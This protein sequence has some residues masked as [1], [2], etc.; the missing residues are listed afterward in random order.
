MDWIE[1]GWNYFLSL[2]L[3]FLASAY[4]LSFDEHLK[5]KSEMSWLSLSLV[6]YAKWFCIRTNPKMWLFKYVRHWY[7]IIVVV[8]VIKR[9]ILSI[10]FAQEL[11]INFW[12]FKLMHGIVF[13]SNGRQKKLEAKKKNTNDLKWKC[14][15]EFV[16]VATHFQCFQI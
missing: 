12:F 7:I 11:S 3:K 4:M 1:L 13:P 2:G 15:Y 14:M 10:T 5:E 9:I 8:V 16:R 6:P